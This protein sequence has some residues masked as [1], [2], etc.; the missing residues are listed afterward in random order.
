MVRSI[1]QIDVKIYYTS[2]LEESV[3][4]NCLYYQRQSTN[5]MRFLS[6]YQG[7]F[8][9]TGTNNHKICIKYQYQK[10]LNTQNNFKKEKQDRVKWWNRRMWN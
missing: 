4:L 7:I 10:I 6:K 8:H 5:S 3:L 1:K 2:R 9:R